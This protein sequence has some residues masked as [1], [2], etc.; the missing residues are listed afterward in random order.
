MMDYQE[1]YESTKAAFTDALAGV[2][3]QPIMMRIDPFDAEDEDGE[4]IRIIGVYDDHNEMRFIAIHE[5]ENGEI[6]P[7][8]ISPIYK[9]G[10]AAGASK[11]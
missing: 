8:P 3:Q 10:T 2:K 6:Y 7:S 11:P 1:H 4:P 5:Q 9:K